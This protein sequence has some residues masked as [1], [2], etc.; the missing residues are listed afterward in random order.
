MR[1]DAFFAD[2]SDQAYVGPHMSGRSLRCLS[3]HA[4]LVRALQVPQS[5]LVRFSHL[6]YFQRLLRFRLMHT[7]PSYTTPSRMYMQIPRDFCIILTSRRPTIQEESR[8]SRVRSIVWVST[9]HQVFTGECR[10][11]P[12]REHV[13]AVVEEERALLFPAIPSL[14]FPH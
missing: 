10:I 6:V 14:Y 13:R 7:V 9:W 4:T 5:R 3:S 12:C 2:M 1:S 8:T 11:A